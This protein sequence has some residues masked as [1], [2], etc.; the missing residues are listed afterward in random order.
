[1]G[2]A[3][4]NFVHSVDRNLLCSVCGGVLQDA[5]LTPCGHSFCSLCL[6]TWLSRRTDD[7]ATSGYDVQLQQGTCPQC[8]SQVSLANSHPVLAIR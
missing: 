1:M 2:Y 7:A 6:K 5:L 4:E 3:I 8:R